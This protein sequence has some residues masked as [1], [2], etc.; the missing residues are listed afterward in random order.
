MHI[1]CRT[2]PLSN[3]LIAVNNN[4]NNNNNKPV[5]EEGDVSVLWNQRVHTDREVTA[6]RT[7]LLLLL[8]LLLFLLQSALQPFVGFR[9][10]QLSLSILSRKVL[11]SAVAR[12][13]SK[14]QLGGEP[15]IFR[16]FQLSPQEAPSVWSD[17]SE[18]NSGRWSY[19][20]EMAEKFCRK[21]RLP[22]HYWVLLISV[23]HDMGQT[24]LLPL[25]RKACWG[26]FHPKNPRA[27]AGFEPAKSGTK[28]QHA[29]SWPPK[30]L[31]LIGQI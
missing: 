9:P 3:N 17:T 26:F 29:T 8:L 18:P 10:A 31:Q 6:N 15:V 20:R 24:A 13:T 7:L 25:R 12:G 19:G 11:Q 14:L 1:K 16:A 2:L 5:Y 4:N 30:P 21:W 22:R 23:K 28:G 27:S